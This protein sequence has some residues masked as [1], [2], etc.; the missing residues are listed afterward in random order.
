MQ[1]TAIPRTLVKATLDGLRLP[2]STIERVTGQTQNAAW[3]PAMVFEGFEAG[4]KQFVGALLRDDELVEE[5]RIQQAKIS[6]LRRAIELEVKADQKRAQ[7]D[8]ELRQRRDQVARDR[9]LADEKAREREQAIEDE[10]REAQQKVDAQARRAEAVV[11]KV[12]QK[13]D[14]R[15]AATE[16]QTRLASVSAESDALAK[17]RKAV[18]SADKV[19]R[20]A[21]AVETKKAQRKSS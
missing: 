20:L 5:G 1:L 16:R 18:A 2:L 13:R 12:D 17:Q 8:A 14:E 10:K 7:A 6:E 4:T 3:P 15:V 11:A 9:R 19:A 21:D